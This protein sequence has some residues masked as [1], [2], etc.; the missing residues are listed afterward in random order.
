MCQSASVIVLKTCEGDYDE[1]EVVFATYV[2][3]LVN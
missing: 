3:T 2:G 1:G